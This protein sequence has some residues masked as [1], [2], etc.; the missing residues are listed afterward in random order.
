[1]NEHIEP[2]TALWAFH[3]IQPSSY[4][5]CCIFHLRIALIS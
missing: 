2:N 3:V 1:M 5:L 4:R